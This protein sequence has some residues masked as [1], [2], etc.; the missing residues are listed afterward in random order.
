MRLGVMPRKIPV[1][2]N[3][4][5]FQIYVTEMSIEIAEAMKLHD[6]VYKMVLHD[7]LFCIRVHN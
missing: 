5:L 2:H 3:R 4:N 7:R 6:A 1:A